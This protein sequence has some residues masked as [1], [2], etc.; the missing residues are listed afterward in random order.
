MNILQT[1]L[2]AGNGEVIQQV[3]RQFGIEPAKATAALSALLPALAGGLKEKLES[4]ASPEITRMLSTGNLGQFVENPRTLASPA[5]LNHGRML[6]AAIFGT[7]DT[8]HLVSMIA[9]RVELGS[10]VIA[11][12]LP[13]AAT[14]LGGFLTK[15]A[16]AGGTLPDTL[17][18]IANAGHSGVLDAVRSLASRI[19]R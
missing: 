10:S 8:S 11:S 13:I 3:A 7:E 15:D 6:L 19:L 4:G 14:L 5:A 12:I 16:V 17:D 1:M 9:E 18:H 2:A